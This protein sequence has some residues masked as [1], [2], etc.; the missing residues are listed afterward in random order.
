ML[1]LRRFTYAIAFASFVASSV[2]ACGSDKTPTPPTPVDPMPS[3]KEEATQ[4]P[5]AMISTPRGVQY[6]EAARAIFR[7]ALPYAEL[8]HFTPSGDRLVVTPAAPK[9]K[10]A[11]VALSLPRV[12]NGSMTIESRGVR[13]TITAKNLTDSKIELA[14]QLA[15]YADAAEGMHLFRRID[16]HGV[17]DFVEAT[18]E[19]DEVSIAYD[20]ALDHA[21]GVRFVGGVVELLDASGTPGLRVKAP[22]AVDAKGVKRSA[23]LSISGCAYDTDPRG[24]WGRSVVE[25]ESSHCTVVA[26]VDARGLAFPV[27]LDPAWVATFNMVQVHAFH[28]LWMMTAGADVGKVLCIGG[29]GSAPLST[30]LFDPAT[31]SWSPSSSIGIDSSGFGQGTSS[32]LLSNGNVLMAGGYNAVGTTTSARSSAVLRKTDATWAFAHVMTAARSFH[33]LTSFTKGGKE[34]VLAAGGAI[35]TSSTPVSSAEIYDVA[36][37][38]WTTTGAMSTVRQQAAAA[39]LASGKIVVAGGNTS[40]TSGF[41][42]TVATTATDIYDPAGGAVGTWTT[43]PAL[44][45]AR[46]NPA[47]VAPPSSYGAVVAGGFN[48]TTTLSSVEGLDAAATSWTTLTPKLATTRQAMSATSLPDG[49]IMFLGGGT[50][51]STTITVTYTTDVY[52]SAAGTIVGGPTM[53]LQRW[54]HDSTR[55]GGAKGILVA[56]GWTTSTGSETAE[57]EVLDLTVGV[58]CSSGCAPGLTC[59]DGVCCT[60][61]T[62]PS[63]EK[64]NSPGHE[65]VCTKPQGA[66]CI[67]NFECATGYCVGGYCCDGPCTGTCKSC[68]VTGSEGTCVLAS[69]GTDPGGICGVGASSPDC[70]HKCDGTGKCSVTYPPSTTPCGVSL[71][72]GGGPF[73]TVQRCDG[74]GGCKTTVNDCGLSCT[75]S[76]T[77]DE[78]T[79]TCTASPTGIKAGYCVIEATCW[80]YGDI[81]PK[82]ACQQCDPPTSKTD[83]TPV[84][85]CVDAGPLD[86]GDA[87]DAATDAHDAADAPSDGG[88]AKSDASS[89]AKDGGD[90]AADAKDAASDAT[91]D[92]ATDDSTV[93][94]DSSTEAPS[95]SSSGCGC[96]TAGESGESRLGALAGLAVALVAVRRRA[97]R[98]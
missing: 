27:L 52:D 75:S 61:A 4:S 15:V 7:D 6:V 36:A 25:P 92:G 69:A 48:G 82:N 42:A 21:A 17:E 1:Q 60:Q 22:F 31:N 35:S 49:R 58:P 39:K 8:D 51:D 63:G 64:C 2:A 79:K 44:K 93:S 96:R 55:L 19:Q 74:S 5:A 40:A 90:G 66:K 50:G 98:G 91:T 65:G 54:N 94:I 53:L 56:G 30:E 45:A 13:A 37:D 38:T 83:W 76:V 11:E 28:R 80:T 81:N 34:M 78:T 26:R 71:T 67:T 12:A 68:D 73:C 9:N 46:Y 70:G 87:G 41:G 97:R 89:D 29:T 84:V 88:D 33:T 47:M 43:G 86:A 32:V 57:S 59:T 3:T 14:E 72:D 18:R 85:G 16:R 23:E 20:V 95:S 77:C 24:P 10:L 62:C